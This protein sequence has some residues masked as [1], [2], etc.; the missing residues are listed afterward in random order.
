MQDLSEDE[1]MSEAWDYYNKCRSFEFK[2]YG[3][4]F[5]ATKILFFPTGFSV[6]PRAG[7]LDD[8]PFMLMEYFFAFLDGERLAFYDK[9][10]EGGGA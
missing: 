4:G 1:Q 10:S 3:G 6:L 9:M 5:G 8:Q 2:Q 7:G